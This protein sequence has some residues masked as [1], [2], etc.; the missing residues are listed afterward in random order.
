MAVSYNKQEKGYQLGGEERKKATRRMEA[1]LLWGKN[2]FAEKEREK[3]LIVGTL[4][5]GEK[6]NPLARK[7]K[8]RTARQCLGEG[9]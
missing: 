2:S 5:G 9:P 4:L 3:A 8:Q 7:K 1:A 6:I